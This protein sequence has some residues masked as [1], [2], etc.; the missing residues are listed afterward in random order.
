MKL[1]GKR[2]KERFISSEKSKPAEDPVDFTNKRVQH[3]WPIIIAAVIC[4]AIGSH[5]GLS[6]TV[7]LTNHTGV[8]NR[9]P[10]MVEPG[11]VHPDPLHPDLHRGVGGVC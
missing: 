11:V 4:P 1:K 5:P 2:N 3:P 7:S 8:P 10:V 9:G 6:C